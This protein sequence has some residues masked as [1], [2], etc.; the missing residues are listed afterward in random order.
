[1]RAISFSCGVNSLILFVLVNF[2]RTKI[3]NQ[4]V[5]YTQVGVLMVGSMAIAAPDTLATL[6]QT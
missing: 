3:S 4:I 1:M 2:H 5:F 6:F